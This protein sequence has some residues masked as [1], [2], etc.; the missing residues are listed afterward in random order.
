MELSDQDRDFH[1]E[2]TSGKKIKRTKA[3]SNLGIL[4]GGLIFLA[5][6]IGT[7]YYL[8]L[9]STPTSKIRDTLIIFMAFELLLIGITI[10]LFV[11]QT[12]RL[13]NL[14]Q[15]EIKPLLNTIN[16]TMGTLRGTAVFLGD[17][18]VKPV[19]RFNS[20]ISAFRRILDIFNFKRSR[21]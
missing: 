12:A 21:E 8:L 10:I 18:L 16:E 14:F 15:N 2:K 5:I 1:A 19:I 11:L 3:L 13:I 4:L 17:S 6:F 9:D 20:Y 7:I